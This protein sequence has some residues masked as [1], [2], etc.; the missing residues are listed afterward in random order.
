MVIKSIDRF[1]KILKILK[2]IHSHLLLNYWEIFNYVIFQ[3]IDR[4]SLIL[5]SK[6]S[7]FFLNLVLQLQKILPAFLS[8]FLLLKLLEAF[9][10][11][12]FDLRFKHCIGTRYISLYVLLYLLLK[13][14]KTLVLKLQA[15]LNAHVSPCIFYVR[16]A[17]IINRF[18]VWF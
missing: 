2:L 12:S 4:L 8:Y 5:N 16:Y 7:Y 15:F 11:N 3:D 6:H 10:F 14:L 17:S 18:Q 1:Q 9:F 13:K